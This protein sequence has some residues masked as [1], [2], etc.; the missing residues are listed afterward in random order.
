MLFDKESQYNVQHQHQLASSISLLK[1]LK[2]SICWL[3]LHSKIYRSRRCWICI[4][5]PHCG[6]FTWI[7]RFEALTVQISIFTSP[8]SIAQLINYMVIS[9]CFSAHRYSYSNTVLSIFF[10]RCVVSFYGFTVV[11]MFFYFFFEP[12]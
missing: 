1:L 10:N 4:I 2:C 8:T 9:S 7:S 5:Y 6:S 11:N 12:I 3:S